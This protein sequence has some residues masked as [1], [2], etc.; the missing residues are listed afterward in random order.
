MLA[1]V[2]L[3]GCG[4]GDDAFDLG[5]NNTGRGGGGALP[6]GSSGADAGD[7]DASP[8]GDIP[9]DGVVFVTGPGDFSLLTS[10]LTPLFASGDNIAT[11]DVHI[12]PDRGNLVWS[13]GA[14]LRLAAPDG[15]AERTLNQ[16]IDGAPLVR[17]PRF[18]PDGNAVFFA[19]GTPGGAGFATSALYRV[20]LDMDIAQ[21]TRVTASAATCAVF[22]DITARGPSR[23]VAVRDG[24]ADPGDGGL[25]EVLTS[26]GSATP[27]LRNVPEAPGVIVATALSRDRS[28]VYAWA[29]GSFDTN[30]DA[31]ADVEVTGIYA[32]DLAAGDL[33]TYEPV[34]DGTVTSIAARADGVVLGVQRQNGDQ[35]LVAVALGSGGVAALTTTGDARSPVTF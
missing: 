17:S 28:T 3:V 8:L 11:G 2:L 22:R 26:T 10:A 24:C 9:A 6:G 12:A 27:L 13:T 23:I 7:D 32:I 29:S 21:P 5:A 30:G 20:P 1:C 34:I 18:S 25:H 14:A 19:A 16:P 33:T 4:G 15:G 31:T 35:D